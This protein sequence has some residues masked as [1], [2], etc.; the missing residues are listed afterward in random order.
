MKKLGFAVFAA[1]GLFG[2]DGASAQAPGSTDDID[3]SDGKTW[4]CRPGRQDACAI[5]LT[6]TV[7]AADG[8]F[9]RETFA[10]DPKAPID[11]FY[12]YPTVSTDPGV[13]SDMTADPAELNVVATQFACFAS[14]CRPFAPLYRQV[15]L[16]GLRAAMATPISPS[17]TSSTSLDRKRGRI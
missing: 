11:C 17:G 14:K 16:A 10:P 5:D 12:V 6:T 13:N 1:A 9:T 8:T 15:T 7:I 3:Y 2:A 4:L